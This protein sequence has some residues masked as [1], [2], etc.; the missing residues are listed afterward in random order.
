M[1]LTPPSPINALYE[2]NSDKNSG[3]NYQFE[4]VVRSATA[5]KKMHASDCDCCK[6]VRSPPTTLLWRCPNSRSSITM[7]WVQCRLDY[8]PLAGHPLPGSRRNHHHRLTQVKHQSRCN[9]INSK[10]PG[11]V[12]TG[13]QPRRP[14][15]F[16]WVNEPVSSLPRRSPFCREIGFPDTQQVSDINRRAEDMHQRKRQRIEQE[17]RYAPFAICRRS[18]SFAWKA[19]VTAATRGSSCLKWPRMDPDVTCWIAEFYEEIALSEST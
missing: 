5:R 10:Y 11:T 12:N 1:V 9:T 7:Q 16:W 8:N 19:G 14:P 13:K 17:A 2:I 3:V 6:D 15:D 4:E 18:V